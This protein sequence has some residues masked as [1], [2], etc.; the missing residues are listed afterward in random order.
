LLAP[1]SRNAEL[2][3]IGP[4]APSPAVN[5]SLD[6]VLTWLETNRL[7]YP[8]PEKLSGTSDARNGKV[9]GTYTDPA[10]KKAIPFSGVVFQKQNLAG[11]VFVNGAR[12]GALRI[13]PGTY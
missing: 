4:S 10:T 3:L 7:V 5:G 9:S 11:G 13:L 2:S 12:S 6:R 8:G 1:T